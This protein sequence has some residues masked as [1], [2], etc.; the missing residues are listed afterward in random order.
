MSKRGISVILLL[1]V[2]IRGAFASSAD[3]GG[4]PGGPSGWAQA[5]V[6]QA[7]LLGLVP[8]EL[9]NAY[10]APVTRREFCRLIANLYDIWYLSGKAGTVGQGTPG[11][12][13]PEPVFGDTDDPDVLLCASLG[14]VGGRGNGI[15]D[16]DA[17]ITRQ[18]AAKMLYSA[19]DKLTSLIADEAA[20]AS[21]LAS[22]FPHV[23]SDGN[24]IQNF[25]RNGIYWVYRQGIMT[26]VPGNAFDPVGTYTREQ[27]Y[28]TMLRLYNANGGGEP[29][30]KP[31]PEYYPY[32][33]GYIDS[34]GN[35]Y[36]K[37]EKGYIYPFDREYEV[38]LDN[39]SNI[40][41]PG[42]HIIDRKGAALLSDFKG[43]SGH[44]SY[45]IVSGHLVMLTYDGAPSV[46]VVNLKTGATYENAQLGIPSGGMTM[47]IADQKYGYMNDAGDLAIEP[48]YEDAGDFLGGRAVVRRQDGGW[49]VIDQNGKVI[50]ADFLDT[51]KYT[52]MTNREYRLGENAIVQNGEGQCAVYS[53]LT[54]LLTDFDYDHIV[55]CRN[56]QFIA[57]KNG[58]YLL[59]GRDGKPIS[60]EY[61]NRFEEIDSGH[62]IGWISHASDGQNA[63]HYAFVDETGREVQT[64]S[65]FGGL[66]S[67]GGTDGYYRFSPVYP[68][69]GGLYLYQQDEAQLAVMDWEGNKLGTLEDGEPFGFRNGLVYIGDRYYLPDGTPVFES[70]A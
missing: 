38:V 57:S 60:K 7:I 50:K 2:L 16:P 61:R 44:F 11:G 15:F 40:M 20:S 21:A 3:A 56:G 53:G 14:I 41:N 17:P 47:F 1:F 66:Y 4:A 29:N 8:G 46:Y 23:F 52:L 30:E 54:G 5:E 45:A 25:A 58:F 12:T 22:N 13:D 32:G 33:D 64:I 55:C 19:A 48:Q 69:G 43:T 39:P 70:P 10:D 67:D 24:R 62:Y 68:D 59:L 65:L 31:E 9:Q 6:S 42:T 63:D 34:S 27:A 37:E 26:G 49:D 35:N 18:E 36:T 28:L 51:T